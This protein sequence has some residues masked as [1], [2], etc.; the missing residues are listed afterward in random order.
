MMK[1]SGWPLESDVNDSTCTSQYEGGAAAIWHKCDSGCTVVSSVFGRQFS[2]MAANT[3]SFMRLLMSE[4]IAS[5]AGETNF[6]SD[7]GGLAHEEDS[8]TKNSKA[9]GNKLFGI[10]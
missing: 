4:M 9:A 10:V 5:I 3:G 6:L 2:K 1:L 7:G 8:K